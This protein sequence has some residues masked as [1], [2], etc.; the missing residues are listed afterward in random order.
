MY[1]KDL[2]L[3]LGEKTKQPVTIKD[4]EWEVL[5]RKALGTIRLCL[6][7]PVNFNISKEKTIEGVMS[8]LA[9]L[10]K[11]PSTSSKVVLMKPLFNINMSEG[12]FFV[13]HLN[14]FNTITS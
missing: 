12:G 3:P 7:S 9:K 13:H 2:Y 11:K 6:V 4:E 14:E 8:A 5:D 10:Y 1:Q